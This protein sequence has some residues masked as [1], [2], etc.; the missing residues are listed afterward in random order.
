MPRAA[1]PTPTTAARHVKALRS[2]GV[3]VA[4]VRIEPDGTLRV[5]IGAPKPDTPRN[6][7]DAP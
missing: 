3:E 4:E 7:W 1:L 5:L 2:V 6:E